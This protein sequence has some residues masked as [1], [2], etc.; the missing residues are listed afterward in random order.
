MKKLLLVIFAF[1]IS[2]CMSV[3]EMNTKFSEIDRVWLLEYQK[4]E[5]LYRFRVVDAPYG[6]VFSKVKKNFNA[7]GL[8]VTSSNIDNGVIVGAVN[9]PTPLSKEEWLEVREI[10]QP[11]VREIGGWMFYMAK[12]PKDYIITVRVRMKPLGEQTLILLEYELDMPEYR[13]MGLTP[14]KV[15]PPT[16]V[17]I[18]SMKFWQ[19]LDELLNSEKLPK[20]KSGSKKEDL[21]V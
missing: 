20:T 15:A 19:K 10:E 2:A 7:L 5:D 1:V 16:A 21:W 6:Q 17:K 18:G 14:N 3:P 11:R 4:H 12:D 9:A 13:E 8:P